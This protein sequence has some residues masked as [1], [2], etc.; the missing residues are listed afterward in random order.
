MRV[1]M[2]CDAAGGVWTYALDLA[3]GLRRQGIDTVLAGFGAPPSAARMA[4][5]RAV[6]DLRWTG[7]PL[8][9]TVPDRADL[10]AVAPALDA[11]VAATGADVLQVNAPSQ[12]AGLTTRAR[13]IAVTH[14]CV[15]TW[16]R[17]VR[18]SD[19]PP[20]WR[21]QRDLNAEGMARADQVLAPSRA[22]AD[23]TARCYPAAG[24]ICVVPNAIATPAQGLH[25]QPFVYA[26]ARWWDEGKDAATLDAAA[27]LTDWPVLA[28]GPVARDGVAA[29][30]FHHA[31]A[32]GSRPHAD[33]RRA[34]A[35]AGIFISPSVYEPFGLAALEAAAGGAALVLSDIPTY[36]EIWADAALFAPPGDAAAFAARINDLS[37]NDQLRARLAEA[38]Q[39]RARQFCP[40]R[41]AR[42]M[43]A[44]FAAPHQERKLA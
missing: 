16:F 43:A 5:A 29:A 13:V 12:A 25:R 14:S 6:A 37:R 36:R 18:G 21:W 33:L 10:A 40:D 7:L 22:H 32:Q 2:T 20:A 44:L 26:A 34:A 41:Q 39:R 31:K 1:L 4:E 38:G 23:L 27:A 8:D 17:A 3:R 28:Y 24:P 15:V 30:A 35:E 11:L 19:V 42:A 9:W